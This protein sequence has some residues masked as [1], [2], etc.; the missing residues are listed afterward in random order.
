MKVLVITEENNIDRYQNVCKHYVI[1]HWMTPVLIYL[2]QI[3]YFLQETYGRVFHQKSLEV[4]WYIV[5]GNHDYRG[6]I[7]A[8]I[9]YT[10]VSKRW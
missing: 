3:K 10:K 5:G 1:E 7:S 2:L 9:A 6:N 4:D 8:Q